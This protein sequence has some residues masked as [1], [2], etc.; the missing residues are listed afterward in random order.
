M[1]S[2]KSSPVTLYRYVLGYFFV[3]AYMRI[4]SSSVKGGFC[5]TALF[6]SAPAPWVLL[7]PRRV[8]RESF[9]RGSI[10]RTASPCSSSR[11][12]VSLKRN[13]P[14]QEQTA[15]LADEEHGRTPDQTHA[16]FPTLA[17][18]TIRYES[19]SPSLTNIS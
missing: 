19:F 7:H 17:V 10:Q 4:S 11:S 6:R 5:F 18:D 14:F 16:S 1:K 8:A 13:E 15:V 3:A 12:R 2:A 9:V